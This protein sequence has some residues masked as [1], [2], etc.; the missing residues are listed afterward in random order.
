[1]LAQISQQ[2]LLTG[3]QKQ[4]IISFGAPS[5]PEVFVHV[6]HHELR[7]VHEQGIQEV[8][9]EEQSFRS[10]LEKGEGKWPAV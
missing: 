9:N 5:R 10:S 6:E 4:D 2:K 3:F 8:S 7:D 1:M